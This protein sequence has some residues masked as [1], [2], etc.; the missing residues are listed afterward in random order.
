M[1]A[2]L[3]EIDPVAVITPSDMTAELG[4]EFIKIYGAHVIMECVNRIYCADPERK[5]NWDLSNFVPSSASNE[6]A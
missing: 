1:V 6:Q 3:P 5:E 2:T 4:A